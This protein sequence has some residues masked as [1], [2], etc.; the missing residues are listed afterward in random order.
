MY[1]VRFALGLVLCVG[2]L[3]GCSPS[4]SVPS[5]I[6]GSVTYKGQPVTAGL[7]TFHSENMG[8]YKAPLAPDG[9]YQASDLPLGNMVVTVETE[10]ANPDK[11]APDY[12]G[13]GKA[14][15]MYEERL[16]AEKK[17]SMGSPMGPGGPPPGKYTKIPA[18]YSNSKSSPLTVTLTAGR[19]VKDFDLTD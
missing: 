11:K 4:S 13:G 10:S 3:A 16:A 18:K 8:S 15:K 2:L 12:A 5:R 7:V 14:G 6:S 1:T 19:N 17:S 9:T